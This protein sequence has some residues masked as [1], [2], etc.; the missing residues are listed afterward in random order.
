M[1]SFQRV[2]DGAMRK[3]WQNQTGMIYT[4]PSV[5][6]NLQKNISTCMICVC[7]IHSTHVRQDE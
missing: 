3:R 1:S 2:F 6:Q 4:F 7:N 5:F